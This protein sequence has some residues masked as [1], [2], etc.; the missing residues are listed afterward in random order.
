[1][2]LAA[3]ALCGAMAMAPAMAKVAVAAGVLD[4]PAGLD[5]AGQREYR[6]FL[7]ANLPRAVA[8]ST[9]GGIGWS[10]GASG[11]AA[12]AA[13]LAACRVRGHGGCALYAEGLDVVWPGRVAPAPTPPGPLIET[14]NFALV[15]DRR[16][17]WWG[18]GGAAGVLV[19]AHG[20]SGDRDSRGLQPPEVVRAF[21]NAGFDIVRFDREPNVDERERAAGWLRQCLA[22][23]RRQGYRKVIAAGQS[24]GGWTALQML[25]QPGLADAVIALSPAAQG[26]AGSGNLFSQSDELRRLV[27]TV[28]ASDARVV[29]ATFADDLLDADP[30][31][32]AALL[33]Q[34][35]PR[36]G[37]ELLIDRPAGLEGHFAG[38]TPEFASRFGVCLV[39]FV[40]GGSG[41]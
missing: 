1:M 36:V 27:D 18:A 12:A 25:S 28:A 10:R 23:L 35:R 37:G 32:R 17:L 16:F 15:P 30:D 34:L 24:R 26:M 33:T 5:A 6:A 2:R 41:C 13:A 7:G 8:V 14:W 19:W 38:M 40:L 9:A 11:D 21:N 4:L 39:G 22:L 31:R 29:V 20:R 3:A